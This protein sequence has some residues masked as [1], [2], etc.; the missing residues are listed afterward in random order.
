MKL[1]ERA[2]KGDAEGLNRL[3]GAVKMRLYEYTV[4]MTLDEALAEDIVQES[5]LTMVQDIGILRDSR[6]FWPWL[7]KIATNKV[8]HHY[9]RNGRRS[10][11]LSNRSPSLSKDGPP[12]SSDAQDAVADAISKEIRQLVLSAMHRLPVE[13]RLILNMRCYEEMS[14]GEIAESLGCRKFKARALFAKAKRALG[15]NLT[16]S[17]LGKASLL[18]ALVIYGKLTA[19]SEA[20]GMATSV[21]AASLKTGLLP[22]LVAVITTRAALVTVAVVGVSA[23]ATSL[24]VDKP[25]DGGLLAAASPHAVSVV[26][27]KD[28]QI[29]RQ[30]WYYYPPRSEGAVLIH[31]GTVADDGKSQWHW[32]QN[33][34]GNYWCSDRAVERRNAHYYC[35]DLATMRLPTDSAALRAFLDD[36]EGRATSIKQVRPPQKGL[37]VVTGT[38]DN[39]PFT[40][41]RADYDVTD[42]QVFQ[43]P[44]QPD[45]K[46]TDR[47]DALHQE[48]WGYLRISGQIN[49]R[50][51]TGTGCIPFV[52]AKRRTMTP[53]LR[54]AVEGSLVLEDNSNAAVVC[55]SA[56]RIR[57]RFAGGMFLKGLPRPW[58]GLHTIDTIRRDAAGYHLRFETRNATEDR[59]V[60]VAVIDRDVEV[61][62]T[63]DLD[64]DVL[65]EITLYEGQSEAGKLRLEYGPDL[66]DGFDAGP[67][68][69]TARRRL[70]R[71]RRSDTLWPLSLMQAAWD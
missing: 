58:E 5:L 52:L 48:G 36:V 39:G 15:R 54:L 70:P 40:R 14:F 30:H 62:Y 27:A 47:R 71:Q 18:G 25:G 12:S 16:Q 2:Q 1:V 41:V 45:V 34:D 6:Q 19:T 64:Q 69:E 22:T 59:H 57:H 50:A 9:R 33:E 68:I 56:G 65:R 42:E 3:A 26:G 46:I 7:T 13:H 29:H 63:I 8:R 4:R 11:L 55:D 37:L 20:S 66:E 38:D 35:P 21:A 60:D 32:F 31:V 24:V 23:T 10:T 61:V 44:W 51:I 28:P 49:G 67:G 17:G 53:W 43:Y